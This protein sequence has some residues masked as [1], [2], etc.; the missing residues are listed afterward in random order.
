LPAYEPP[1]VTTYSDEQL[2][3]ALGPAQARTYA[4]G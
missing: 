2:L 3:E 1:T 4:V